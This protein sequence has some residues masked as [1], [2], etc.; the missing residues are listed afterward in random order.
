MNLPPELSTIRVRSAPAGGRKTMYHH[1]PS[2]LEGPVS[3]ALWPR[4]SP[5]AGDSHCQVAT[6]SRDDAVLFRPE[7]VA[8]VRREIAA[9]TYETQQ[10]WEIALEEL[11]HA[12]ES[13]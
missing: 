5:R 4:T 9:G 2:C 10:K 11:L 3:V 7:L 6:I 12:L 1:D 8:R 13:R